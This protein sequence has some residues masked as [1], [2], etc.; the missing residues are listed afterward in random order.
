MHQGVV[1]DW[2]VS[3][4]FMPFGVMVKCVV[5]GDLAVWPHSEDGEVLEITDRG[6]RVQGVGKVRF[7]LAQAGTVRE[8]EVDFT[9]SPVQEV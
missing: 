2:C 7:T 1:D 5:K 3:F 9:S 4:I 8:V 6:A